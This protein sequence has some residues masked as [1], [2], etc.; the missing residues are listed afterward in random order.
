[1]FSIW[2]AKE[3]YLSAIVGALK[4]VGKVMTDASEICD[5]YG[6][7][8]DTEKYGFKVIKPIDENENESISLEE[9]DHKQKMLEFE[10]RILNEIKTS[11][12]VK[13]P[14]LKPRDG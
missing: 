14:L 5:F 11:S 1:M 9:A 13:K 4:Y 10:T 7:L 8:N 6:V 12:I 2:P 3:K